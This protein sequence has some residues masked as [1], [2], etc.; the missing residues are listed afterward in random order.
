MC[1]DQVGKPILLERVCVCLFIACG[2]MNEEHEIRPRTQEGCSGEGT[3]VGFEE[4]P[5][6]VN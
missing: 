1:G 6:K 3:E 2:N 5:S 4:T